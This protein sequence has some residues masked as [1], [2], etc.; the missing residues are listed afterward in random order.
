VTVKPILFSAPMVRALLEGRKT[1]TR[2][3]YKNRNGWSDQD[4]ESRI[5]RFAFAYPYDF[6]DLLW[7]RETW[8]GDYLFADT[9]PAQRDSYMTPDGPVLRDEIWFWADGAPT[10]GDWERPRPGIHMPRW[11]SR[12]TLEVT[13]VKIERLQEISEQ[14]AIAEGASCLVTDGEGKFYESE[15]G[16]HRCGFAGLWAHINGADSWDANPWV[17]AVTFLV[18][19][20]NVDV[21]LAQRK[22][23][24]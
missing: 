3:I 20:Q 9:P 14:D 16:T 12:L 8:S 1:Q 11:A 2:R 4:I 19:E 22:E 15:R 17:V 13:G 21:I 24:A 7:V 5:R 18:H 23:A 6:G 10:H